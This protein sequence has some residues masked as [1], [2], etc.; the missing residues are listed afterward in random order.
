MEP[1]SARNPRVQQLRKL[2][3]QRKAR[4]QAGLFVLEGAGLLAEAIACG[5]SI[6]DVFLAEHTELDPTL[7]AALARADVA[8]WAL[9]PSVLAAAASTSSPQ[10]V[11]A[12]AELPAIAVADAIGPQTSF[13]VIGAGVSDP[14]NAGTLIRTAAAAGANAVVF[15]DDSVDVFNPKVVRAS[16]GAL[17]RLPVV[18]N[19]EPDELWDVL[20]ECSIATIG[21]AGS[22]ETDYDKLDL[23]A[24]V[25]LVVGNEAHGLSAATATRVERLVRIPMAAGVESINVSA[26]VAAVCF[27][28][29][30]QRR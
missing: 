3:R 10:P 6:R 8:A 9:D 26:A 25:A 13:V 7:A 27:E 2:V 19:A 1:I 28:V 11:I 17:F 4:D 14:G 20:A 22:A 15:C 29:S 24:N 18:P 21:L 30:R 5:L 16:A 12:T 23:T